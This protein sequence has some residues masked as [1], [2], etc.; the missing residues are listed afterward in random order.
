MASTEEIK[1]IL[2]TSKFEVQRK[3]K[4]FLFGLMSVGLL[5]FLYGLF[6]GHPEMAWHALLINTIFF[7]GIAHA[8]LGISVIF[9]V[10]DAYWGRPIKRLAEALG[11]FVP[12]STL[13]FLIL[14]LGGE[15]FF[16]W[17]DHDKVIHA[18]AGWLEY[19]F[20]MIR[21]AVCLA[22][23]A[24]LS[25][26]YLQNSLRPDIG[27]AKS[28]D[29][30]YGNSFANRFVKNYGKHDFEVKK[31]FLK[32]K[33]TSIHLGIFYA[34]YT[35]FIAFDWM[36]SIDQE[37]FS[38]M[39]GVQHLIAN[40]IAGLVA[41]MLISGWFRKKHGLADYISLERYHDN[42]KL[43]FAAILLWTYMI[44]SQVI[45]IWY[46]NLPEET[47]YMILRMK[48]VEWGWMFWLLLIVL[49]VIPF[50][51]LMGRTACRSI[52][53]SGII[54]VDVLVGMWLEK[55]FLIVPSLQENAITAVGQAVQTPHGV[56]V[57]SSGLP[58]LEVGPLFLYILVGIGMIGL[59]MFSFSWFIQRVPMIPISDQRLIR[60]VHH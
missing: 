51:G 23:L 60:K 55:Y 22:I 41:L 6:S 30:S 29:P 7:A 31:A 4:M 21:H 5:A 27:L 39:F 42:S 12:F 1:Q 2:D 34:V 47:P 58:G 59:F 17:Y 38:T 25:R 11:S 33:Q 9:T 20:F 3:T 37:W 48:S 13:F 53:F 43:A 57:Y 46:A 16:E 32:N 18:K 14:F 54:A 19:N 40:L 52:W 28:I 35:T 15:Y 8:G 56:Q 24:W 45:V 50:F 26:K 36:M 10:T 44:F 49:F